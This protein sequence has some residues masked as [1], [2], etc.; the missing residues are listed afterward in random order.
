M[1]KP[2]PEP[3]VAELRAT[4]TKLRREVIN[5]ELVISSAESQGDYC[6]WDLIRSMHPDV[7]WASIDA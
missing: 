2:I 4:I 3:D 1:A 5:L 6:D 7:N